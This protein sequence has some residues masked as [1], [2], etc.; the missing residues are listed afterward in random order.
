MFQKLHFKPLADVIFHNVLL[1]LLSLDS[2]DQ[3]VTPFPVLCPLDGELWL[4]PGP[5]RG[6]TV[7]YIVIYAIT[8]FL[9]FI[10]KCALRDA[11]DI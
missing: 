8:A 6:A 4:V 10:G 11:I 5:P 9:R 3:C 2:T 7:Y 1:N